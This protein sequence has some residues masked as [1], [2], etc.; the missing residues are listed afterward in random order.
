MKTLKGK[1]LI[2]RFDVEL[3][4]VEDEGNYYPALAII[5]KK[6]DMKLCYKFLNPNEF[7][8]LIQ[9]RPEVMFTIPSITKYNAEDRE[10]FSGINNF[11]G[12]ISLV[13]TEVELELPETVGSEK[14]LS[15]VTKFLYSRLQTDFWFLVQDEEGMQYC[16]AELFSRTEVPLDTKRV[17]GGI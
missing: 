11:K 15:F 5:S 10:A 14:V 1:V 8:V 13:G 6:E 12:L 16:N 2:N 7:E 3:A 17:L 9:Q 4:A